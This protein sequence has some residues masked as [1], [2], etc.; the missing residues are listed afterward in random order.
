MAP[1]RRTAVLASLSAS[2]IWGLTFL[3][4]KITLGVLGPMGLGLARFAIA[5]VLLAVLIRVRGRVPRL[6]RRDMPRMA[7]GGLVGVTAYFF[8][9]YNG[10]LRISAS[11]A[12]LVTAFIPILTLLSERVFI[13]ARMP[14]RAWAGACISA[15]GIGLIV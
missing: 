10:I 7:A 4:N 3:S 13:G 15:A 2:V 12:S 14:V 6:P 1:S 9:E 5:S 8:F 11:E